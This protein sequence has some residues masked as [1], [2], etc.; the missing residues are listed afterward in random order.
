[1]VYDVSDL[2]YGG[3]YSIEDDIPYSELI[4]SRQTCSQQYK[5]IILT[6]GNTDTY[7]LS[8]SLKL[9]Y[10]HLSDFFSFMDYDA[11]KVQGSSGHLFNMVKPFAGSGIVNNIIAIF[12]NDTAGEVA[13]KNLQNLKLPSNIQVVK[14]PNISLLRIT[15][16]L[17][18]LAMRTLISQI[19]QQVLNCT[20]V[21]IF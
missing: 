20:L 14:L 8:E 10:P 1:M 7:I 18:F 11:T 6:E 2:I 4:M 17:V 9:L 16:Q 19:S 21:L 3:Y 13:F 15:P 12:D 5:T